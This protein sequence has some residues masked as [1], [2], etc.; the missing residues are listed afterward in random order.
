MKLTKFLR[1]AVALVLCV[2][3]VLSLSA[4]CLAA[5][6]TVVTEK[7]TM[8]GIDWGH[9]VTTSEILEWAVTIGC[10]LAVI[11]VLAGVVVTLVLEKKK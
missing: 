3:A 6:T 7:T 10:C 2:A 1:R 11:F 5:T 8:A 9:G 4:G